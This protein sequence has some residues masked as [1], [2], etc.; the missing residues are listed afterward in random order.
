MFDSIRDGFL[1][2]LATLTAHELCLC[3]SSDCLNPLLLSLQSNLISVD[4]TKLFE[5]NAVIAISYLLRSGGWPCSKPRYE[6]H[7]H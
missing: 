3:S 4:V 2:R 5:A 1:H 7:S 6:S